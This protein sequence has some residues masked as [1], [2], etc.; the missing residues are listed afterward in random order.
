M[1]E[2]N[3]L[4][5]AS[6]DLTSHQIQYTQT[7]AT[8]LKQYLG[9]RGLGAKFLFDLVPPHVN[10][11]DPEN[12]LIFSTGSFSGTPWPTASRY[13]VTFKSPATDAYGYANSGGHFGPQLAKSGFNALIITGQS[14]TPV[15][16]HITQNEIAILPAEHLWGKGTYEVQEILLGPDGE[17]GRN[18]RVACIGQAGEN[19]VRIAAIIN[20]YGRAAA[21]GGP[22]AV[23]GSKN[24]K[25][26]HVEGPRKSQ[27]SPAFS[28]ISRGASKQLIN[29]PRQASLMNDG[30]IFLNRIKNITGDFP[31]KNHQLG[32]VPYIDSIDANAINEYKVKR[33]GCAVC[34]IRCSR[35]S[36]IEEEGVV[37]EVEGPEYETANAFGPMVWNDDPKVVIKANYLC[38]DYGLDTISAGVTI[39]FAMECHENNLLDDTQFS[40]EWGDE[41]SILG[42]VELMA[43]REG[44]GNILAEGVHRAAQQLGEGADKYAMHVKG[45]E[46]PRQ[47]PRFAK[48]FGLGHATSNRGADHLYGLPSMDLSGNWEAARDFFPEEKLETLMDPADETYKADILV[49]GEHFCAITDSLGLCKF[50]TSETYSTMPDVLAEGLNALGIESEGKSL[51]KIGERIVNLERLFNLRCGLTRDDDAIPSR[52]L[53]EPLPLLAMETDPTTGETTL[54]RELV[55]GQLDDFDAMLDRYYQLRGWTTEGRPSPTTLKRLGL[56]HEAQ[57]VDES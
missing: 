24:L 53:D 37:T 3:L 54:G 5:T 15:Y 40:L 18:G 45:L 55:V 38:N 8:L 4:L 2:N 12:H 36:V 7:D 39:A 57:V 33:L 31:A 50:T 13:H 21:R 9:G 48:G 23:M 10:A 51:L 52:F 1:K 41:A 6:I 32:Q 16:L 25:A 22:G 47:E 14:P 56:N 29:D 11:Y 43:K 30:T 42:L 34:P 20:D 46:I 35:I 26:I 27:T 17:K 49:L 44:I 19:R 28:A